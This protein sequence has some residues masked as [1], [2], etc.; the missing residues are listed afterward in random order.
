MGGDWGEAGE[1]AGG[2]TEGVAGGRWTSCSCWGLLCLEDGSI[3]H[4]SEGDH[5]SPGTFSR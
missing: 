1:L 4:S 3:V 2:G 5:L